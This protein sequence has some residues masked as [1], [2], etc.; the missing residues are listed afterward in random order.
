M[1]RA[2]LPKSRKRSRVVAVYFLESEYKTLSRLARESRR[3]LSQYVFGVVEEHVLREGD[4]PRKR[5]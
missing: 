2:K 4:K 1:P 5:R 3:P